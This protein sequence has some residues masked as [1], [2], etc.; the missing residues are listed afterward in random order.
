MQEGIRAKRRKAY[1]SISFRC[2][3]VPGSLEVKTSRGEGHVRHCRGEIDQKT[4]QE[5]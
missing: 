5:D 1:V 4:V 2:R 3:P